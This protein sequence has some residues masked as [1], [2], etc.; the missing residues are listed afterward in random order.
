MSLPRIFITIAL[1]F[2]IVANVNSQTYETT[3]EPGDV[4]N[5][6]AFKIW[7]NPDHEKIRGILMLNPGSNGDGRGQVDD[8][9]WQA[10]ANKHQFALMGTY[11]TDHLHPNM[12]IEEYIQVSKGSGKAFI[13]AIDKVARESGHEELSYAPFLLWGMSAGGEINHEIASWIPERVIAY[14]VNKGGYYYSAVPS[15]ATRQTPGL[16]VIGLTD[17]PSRNSMIRGMYLTNRRAGALWTLVEEKGVAH[18]V[19]GSR[20]IAVSYYEAV[21]SLRMKDDA[22][23]YKALLPVTEELG[24]VGNIYKHT[25]GREEGV[26]KEDTTWL[27]TEN[28]ANDWLDLV[29]KEPETTSP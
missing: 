3:I 16:Y 11:F 14:V 6:A 17:L 20:D 22:M 21:M 23:G 19:A 10:F 18:E 9:Y 2:L 12:M 7:I 29:T 26:R 1:S 5:M 4:Y 27:P 8:P 13:D 15:E 25:L 28:F 24:T